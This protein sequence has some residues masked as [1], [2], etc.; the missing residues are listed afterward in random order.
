MAALPGFEDAG[1]DTAQAVLEECARF[2]QGVLEPLDRKGDQQPSTW[3]DG[4]VST[5]PGFADAWRQF[6]E[7]GWQGLQH[8]ADFGGQALPK[9]IAAA[10]IEM[11][12]S[13]NLSFA[14]CAMLTDGAIEALLTA[15]SKELKD[16]WLPRLVSGNGPAR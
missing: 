4:Q 16:T 5:T 10:S 8:P 11:L 12:N 9:T 15:G 1:A 3:K 13:S 14:L 6:A 7:G 2:S